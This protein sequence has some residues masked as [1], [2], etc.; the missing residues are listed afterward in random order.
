MGSR[1]RLGQDGVMAAH[2]NRTNIKKESNKMKIYDFTIE[3]QTEPKGLGVRKPRFSWKME[4]GEKD[5]A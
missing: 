3:Y 2:R 4:S 5:V 1:R